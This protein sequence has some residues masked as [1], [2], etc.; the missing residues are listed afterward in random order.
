[1][2]FTKRIEAHLYELEFSCMETWWSN[3]VKKIS[4][5]SNQFSAIHSET[6]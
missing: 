4:Y 2:S 1:M 6:T 3:S 5:F